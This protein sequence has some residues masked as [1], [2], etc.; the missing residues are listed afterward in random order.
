MVVFIKRLGDYLF[1]YESSSKKLH[2]K[3]SLMY[4]NSVDMEHGLGLIAIFKYSC[5]LMLFTH[6]VT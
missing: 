6:H 4:R 2:I 5:Q 3:I 1:A